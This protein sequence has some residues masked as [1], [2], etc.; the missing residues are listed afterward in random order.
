MENLGQL[1]INGHM[2]GP[3]I[4]AN[5]TQKLIITVYNELTNVE[6]I[7][8]HWHGIHHR[9]MDSEGADGVAYITQRPI[10]PFDKFTYT[11]LASP[12]GTHWYHAHRGAQRTDGLY[13]ALIV[14]D[15]LPEDSSRGE[16]K[17]TDDPHNQTLI[18]MDWQKDASIELFQTI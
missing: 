5:K 11:F 14:H 8:I 7:S 6:G 1:A 3:T 9:M 16:D 2:P 15:D 17:I 13:G 12:S 4:I 18:L 10:V